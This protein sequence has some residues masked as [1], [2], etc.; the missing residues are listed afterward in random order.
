MVFVDLLKKHLLRVLVWNILD[1][2]CRAVVLQIDNIVDI[3]LELRRL[4]RLLI[5]IIAFIQVG[6]LPLVGLVTLSGV[7]V[8]VVIAIAVLSYIDIHLV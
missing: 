7:V 2:D 3:Q 6:R 5:S 1:H 4:S 8:V